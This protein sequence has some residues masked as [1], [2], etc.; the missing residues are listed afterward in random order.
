[1]DLHDHET[2]FTAWRTRDFVRLR[3]MCEAEGGVDR[4][5][6]DDG[7]SLL[8]K[9]VRERDDAMLAF[10]LQFPC[11][12]SLARFDYLGYTP[13][14]AAA[15]DG[16]ADM[17]Q[18]LLDAGADPNAHDEARIGNTAIREA[19]YGGHPEVVATLLRAGA[20]PTIPGWMGIS[21]VDEACGPTKVPVDAA[22]AVA[23]RRLLAPFPSSVRDR[24]DR[25]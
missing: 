5:I 1:M 16:Q 17:V 19:V 10:L 2:E 21:A 4:W 3:A 6:D 14:H 22:Q 8:H 18:R 24:V 11:A 23:I 12:R 7:E 13:L 9:A 20:D 25:R 15:A